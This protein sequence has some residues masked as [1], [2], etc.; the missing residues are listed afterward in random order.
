MLCTLS[1]YVQF[2][3]SLGLGTVWFNPCYKGMS[4]TLGAGRKPLDL[5]CMDSPYSLHSVFPY[6]SHSQYI[7]SMQFAKFGALGRAPLKCCYIFAKIFLE[8]QYLM[9]TNWYN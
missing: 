9:E 6:I 2:T 5:K 8:N 4:L 3:L 1:V 7:T